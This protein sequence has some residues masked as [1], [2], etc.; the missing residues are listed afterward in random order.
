GALTNA[1]LY[2]ED[3]DPVKAKVEIDAA[4]KNEKTIASAKAWYYRG[5]I[6]NRLAAD[7]PA[8]KKGYADTA[9]ISFLQAKTLEKSNGQFYQMSDLRLQDQW[10]A[11]TNDGVKKYQESDFAGAVKSFKL[12]HLASP[13]DTTALLYGSY[14]AL[15]KKDEKQAFEFTEELK[16]NNYFKSHVYKTAADYYLANGDAAKGEAELKEGLVKNPNDPILLQELANFYITT[17]KNEQAVQTLALLEKTNPND[18]LVLINIAVQYQKF[19]Q[20]DQAEKYYLKVLDKEPNNYIALFNLGSLYVDKS[21]VKLNSYNSLNAE[22]YKKQGPALKTE[23][24]ANY[25]KALGYCKKA[26]P[27]AESED[28]KQKLSTMIADLD[29]VLKSLSK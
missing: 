9:I 26:L 13:K 15:A 27:L 18:P 28:D 20:P 25:T 5:M 24:T 7:N 19:N 14:A 29:G 21:R 8:S 1:I 2:L 11:T 6:Y 4:V 10:V 17:D 12:A 3:N 23:L 22:Q 16:K